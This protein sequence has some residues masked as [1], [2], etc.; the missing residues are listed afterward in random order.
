M[1]YN[2]I[3]KN[4]A[5]N[6]AL[7]TLF[8]GPE[9]NIDQ[10]GRSYRTYF[11]EKA[12]DLKVKYCVRENIFLYKSSDKDTRTKLIE[13]YQ[14][15][16]ENV[17][18]KSLYEL[19]AK[20]KFPLIVNAGPDRTL[21]KLFELLQV[22]GQAKLFDS[23][24]RKTTAEESTQYRK[25][26]IETPNRDKPFIYNIFGDI[27]NGKTIITNHSAFYK[28]ISNLMQKVSIPESINN[29]IKDSN[30]LIFL[31]F[32]FESWQ[33][34]LL[35]ERLELGDGENPGNG[36]NSNYQFNQ[37]AIIRKVL[38]EKFNIEFVDDSPLQIM[39]NLVK[40]CEAHPLNGALLR[41]PAPQIQKEIYI[42]YAWDDGSTAISDNLLKVLDSKLDNAEKLVL[43]TEIVKPF[44]KSVTGL[45]TKAEIYSQLIEHDSQATIDPQ[46]VENW[47]QQLPV[48]DTQD[49]V[50]KNYSREAVVNYL[51]AGFLAKGVKVFRDKKVMT[52]GDSIDTFMSR[53]GNGKAV[54]RVISDKYLKSKY[55]MDEA[56]RIDKNKQNANVFNVVLA[57][58][59]PLKEFKKK[60]SDFGR[61]QYQQY[62]REVSTSIFTI[63]DKINVD[64]VEKE[65]IKKDY[66]VYLDI[67]Q[68][69]NRFIKD[70]TD[71]INKN[72]NPGNTD[73]S[74]DVTVPPVDSFDQS[75]KAELD[76][77]INAV[78]QKL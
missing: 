28:S 58:G 25:E 40:A 64:I 78:Y 76:S 66:T 48:V 65:I 23:D 51:E 12:K 68:F 36:Y 75:T 31:G 71:T 39:E 62:W 29:F 42:S 1:V 34:Q 18:D 46:K 77:F 38:P 2:N 74:T 33:Y 35:C 5:T 73:G 4:L 70:V 19:I 59:I 26:P 49:P 20:I 21:N 41:L 43:I 3:V 10:Q 56:L 7:V 63:L 45:P 67:Y 44:G 54:L 60:L 72:I 9:L 14:D 32:D 6:E 47:Y 22:P 8:L 53:I 13:T 69:I 27:S 15:F 57:D 61:W 24:Y 16:Y 50:F 55:C 37:D 11:A 17:G 30:Y 52:L